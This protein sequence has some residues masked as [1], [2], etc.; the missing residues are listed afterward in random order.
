MRASCQTD[1]NAEF[2]ARV[3]A[4]WMGHSIAVAEKH[5]LQV[6]DADM[7]RAVGFGLGARSGAESDTVR[8]RTTK[9]TETLVLEGLRRPVSNPDGTVAKGKLPGKDS[10]LDK[11]YQKLLCYR[12]TTG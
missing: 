4:E 5:C 7:D 11:E 8:H 3:V 12:Y 2:S 6:R 1:R 9:A 10:N